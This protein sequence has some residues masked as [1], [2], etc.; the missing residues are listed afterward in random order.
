MAAHLHDSH[1]RVTS[2]SLE[3]ALGTALAPMYV[4]MI[5]GQPV[6]THF[7]N[8]TLARRGGAQV[9]DVILSVDGE[10][11]HARMRRLARYISASTPQALARSAAIRMTRGVA[12]TTVR[13][14]VR[15]AGGVVRELELT[16]SPDFEL[17]GR[18]GPLFRVLP[19]NI[20]YADLGRLPAS[21]VDTMFDRLRGTRAIIFDVRGYPL[22]TAWPI[23]PRLTRADMPVAARFARP[24]PMS[25]DTTER[26]TVEFT[27]TLGHTDKWRYLKPTVMLIDERT[28]SQ[29]EHTGLFLE[30]ANGTKFVG[31]P[32]MG[33]NGDVT[34]IALPGRVT[35]SFTG[36]AVRHAD[37][38][39][40]QR[41][42]LV[43]DVPVRPTIAGVRAGR[44][45]VLERA[46]HY[47]VTSRPSAR[48]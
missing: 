25:P 15:R 13:L 47:L 44:D 19:G 23:A 17:T 27:Q 7:T 32:T 5:E 45:E 12:G 21:Q 28:L 1:V 6:V 22:G 2:P 39:Q 35:M 8:D 20:G 43:P 24:N 38:R 31:S 9:G 29:A 30:A 11:A 46:V 41:V 14:R 26:A 36:Q 42:G 33:A 18:T 34:V 37:G 16:R 10:E 3:A 4:R 40:L 48:P